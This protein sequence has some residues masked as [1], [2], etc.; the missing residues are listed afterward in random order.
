MINRVQLVVI[1]AIAVIAPAIGWCDDMPPL[2]EGARLTF[3]EDWSSGKIDPERWYPLRKKWGKGNHGVVPE[4]LRIEPD[5][6]AGKRKN[7]LICQANGDRYDGPIIGEGGRKDRV[8]G[9]L[10]TN[11]FFASGRFEVVL[12]IGGT[13]RHEG[14]PDDPRRPIGAVPAIWTYAYRYIDVGREREQEFVRDR[15]LYNPLMKQPGGVNEYWSEIDFPEFGKQGNFERAMYNTFLQNRH[16]NLFFDVTP[17]I[18][19]RYHTL[20]TD[21]R[22]RLVPIEGVRDDQVIEHAGYHWVCDKAILFDKYSSNPLKR[23]GENRYAVY[24]GEV[25]THYLDGRKVGENRKHVPAMA[26]QLNLGIWLP[27]W[28]GPAPWKTATVSIA[29]VRIWQF[30]DAGDVRGVLTDN[31]ADSFD[32]DGK[33]LRR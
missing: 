19:G 23:L 29:S 9:V 22:T 31:I 5:D 26:A 10:V 18:D 14:G 6:V 11:D 33:P 3:S 7:I 15:P 20:V 17:A 13:D 16:D 2:P 8:G 28:A 24:S 32:K 30:N 4:N 12:K 25:A 21:W 1:L 27:D